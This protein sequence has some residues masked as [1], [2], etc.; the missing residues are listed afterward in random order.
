VDYPLFPGGRIPKSGV[1]RVGK[2]RPCCARVPFQ[3]LHRAEELAEIAHIP[4]RCAYGMRRAGTDAAL[5]EGVSLEAL[6]EHGGWTNSA[7]PLEKYRDR[8]RLKGA[9][10]A[11]VARARYRKEVST[12]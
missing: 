10:D 5:D 4:G 12:A 9:Q 6:Q 7:T 2:T 1:C 3:W 8:G 11:A